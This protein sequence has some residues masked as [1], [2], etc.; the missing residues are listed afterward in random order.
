MACYF[1]GAHDMHVS[2]LT[3]NAPTHIS[4]NPLD[5]V[6]SKAAHDAQ[7]DSM[8][9]CDAPKC[10][11]ET[12]RAV[13]E[14]IMGWIEDDDD[15]TSPKKIMWLSG[16][17][18]SGKTAVAG[19]IAECCEERDLLAATFFFSS[20]SSSETVRSKRYLVSTLVYQLTQLDGFEDFG[21]RVMSAIQRNPGIFD[22]QLKAQFS[23]LVLKPLRSLQRE[24]GLPMSPGV[25]IIDGLDEVEAVG[26][27]NLAPHEGRRK[28]EADQVEIL[29]ILLQAAKVPLFPFRIFVASRPERVIQDFFSTNASDTMTE[30]L[31]DDKYDPEA[32]IALFLKAK[33]SEIRRQYRLPSPPPFI[34]PATVIRFLRNGREPVHI[35]LE[36]V[37]RLHSASPGSPHH[38]L[39]LLYTHILTSNPDPLL[40]AQWIWSIN[41]TLATMPALFTRQVLER[42]PGQA[43]YLL[44]SLVSLVHVPSYEDRESPYKLYHKS[45]VHFLLDSRRCGAELHGAFAKGS[46]FFG[47]RHVEILK[48]KSPVVP[49]S[50]SEWQD[51]GRNLFLRLLTRLNLHRICL[52]EQ[53]NFEGDL[54]SCDVVWWVNAVVTTCDSTDTPL[55]ISSRFDEVHLRCPGWPMFDQCNKSCAHWRGSILRGC[56]ALGWR[57]PNVIAF[58][59]DMLSLSPG[60]N[61]DGDY[62]ET[63]DFRRYLK[64][65]EQD[66]GPES[67]TKGPPVLELASLA[68]APGVD[69]DSSL[70]LAKEMYSCLPNDRESR[71]QQEVHQDGKSIYNALRPIV[72]TIKISMGVV[73]EDL[74]V[75]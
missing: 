21:A 38:A 46:D 20:F 43:E 37:L 13:Q 3:I 33:F 4:D 73:A 19:S 44:A 32:D 74:D 45:L 67:L 66:T 63:L 49:L 16:P 8:A 59:R 39:D 47:I 55:I 54:V 69:Y 1:Q 57:V 6:Y 64:P 35:L 5:Y 30:L 15:G 24:G 72:Q 56:Q 51:F 75:G 17:A 71:F 70:Q 10:H 18:G 12:R 48:N 60:V 58:L 50:T 2:K 28:D 25:I 29:S 26:S 68:I 31:L 27:R 34:Y 53:L 62:A 52:D 65:P 36:R 7:Y 11:P 14:G 9:R 42:F 61:T 40:A 23:M 22:K 41:N